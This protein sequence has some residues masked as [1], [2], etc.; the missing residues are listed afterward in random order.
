MTVS[1][2]DEPHTRPPDDA[3][4]GAV[5]A[6]RAADSPATRPGDD[7]KPIGLYTTLRI[8]LVRAFL[9]GWIRLFSLRGLYLLGRAFGT[10][11]Y[12]T[13]YKR[14]RRVHRKLVEFFKD[15]ATPRW[16]RVVARHYF[17]RVRCDKMFYTIMDRIP[18]DKLMSRI[19]FVGRDQ[20]DTHLDKGNGLYVALCHFGSH[21]IAGLIMA[22][23]GYKLIGVRDPKESPV[24][25]YIAKKYRETFPEV[26]AMRYFYSDAFPRELFRCY[27]ENYIVASLL[28]VD[29]RREDQH[30]MH[31]VTIFGETREFLTGPLKVAL[32]CKAP[33]IQGF[34]ISRPNFYYRLVVGGTLYD[35]A[36]PP[37]VVPVA[38]A[39]TSAGPDEEAIIADCLQR[40]ADGVELHAREHPDHLM[41]I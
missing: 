5:P 36:A 25:R 38:G 9:V 16:R 19:R 7:D 14:R 12:L 32:R 26:A 13:D 17:M 23:L 41:K 34:V 4:T 11:E 30:K 31:P 6:A 40:Y 3:R 2:T 35:P 22:L 29:R 33:I 24:R 28:D 15:K 37:G 20:I 39:A 27:K 21:H 8:M 1:A 18:R 10:A